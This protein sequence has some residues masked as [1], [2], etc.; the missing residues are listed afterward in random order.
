LPLLLLVRL[1]LQL[2]QELLLPVWQH[3]TLLLLNV[4]LVLLVWAGYLHIV[5]TDIC[6]IDSTSAST[7]SS[8]IGLPAAAAAAAG[9]HLIHKVLV[10]LH[11]QQQQEGSLQQH[12]T[13]TQQQHHM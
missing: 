3:P 2:L 13:T 4:R 6:I 8:R 7:S 9:H 1:M 11:L 10:L 12:N 5:R